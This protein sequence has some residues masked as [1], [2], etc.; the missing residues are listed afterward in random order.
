M[1]GAM[2]FAVGLFTG[3]A[4]Q[5]ANRAERQR[6]RDDESRRHQR[7]GHRGGDYVLHAEDGLPRSV[8]R[9]RREGTA[10]ARLHADQQEHVSRAEPG[11]RAAA[12]RLHALRTPRRE[13]DRG[14]REVQEERS[15]RDRHE[16]QR[17]E[18]RSWPTSRTRTWAASSWPSSRR[19]RCTTKRS[20]A[21]NE[22]HESTGDRAILTASC[23]S[24]P[25]S[26]RN[27]GEAP[28][29]RT[30]FS[31]STAARTR[32]ASFATGHDCNLAR[33][34]GAAR[35]ASPSTGTASPCGRPTDA[36]RDG[37]GLSRDECKPGSPFRRIREGDQELWRGHVRVAARHPC[38]SRRERVGD[39]RT[40][41]ERRRAREVSRR[42]QEGQRGHQV[43]P[44]RQGPD[45]ARETGR[46][47]NPPEAL[48]DPTDVVT[49]PGNGDIYVAESHTDVTDPNLV[50]RISVFDR[51][52]EVPQG[53]REERHGARRVPDAARAGVRFAGPADRRRP[54][55]PSH[56]DPDEGR[57]VRRRV[58]RLRPD[59]R[60][61]HR[62]ERRHLHR[63]LGVDRTGSP[64]WQRGFRIGSV[65]DGKVTMFIPAHMTPNSPDGAM[66][67]GIA[68]DAAGN[69]YTAEAQLR[70]VTKY[71][72][73]S[74]RRG[75]DNADAGPRIGIE[76]HGIF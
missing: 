49:D 60:P 28:R 62:Q 22:H 76:C 61:G 9:Q 11:E 63:R 32:T 19:S 24:E 64:G 21:G 55:Q 18:S 47:G 33:P 57:Q 66:G 48:T 37:P 74:A 41:R 42:R 65:K 70:G 40:G 58:R 50:G 34:S 29:K 54:P 56:P 5:V 71:V 68:I 72:R 10:A 51:E 43:Q 1:R 3:L 39:R 67:E 2:L 44:R 36:H 6:R 35:T 59:Q 27:S 17:H 16:R 23:C 53:H 12:G 69:I 7:A 26:R 20:R 30:R 52:R 25:A 15:D 75:A 45:D 4:V 8:P 13:R 31:P 14:G 38:R 73:N 46:A